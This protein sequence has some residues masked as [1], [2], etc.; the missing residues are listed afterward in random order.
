M[1]KRARGTHIPGAPLAGLLSARAP[2]LS[3]LLNQSAEGARPRTRLPR[4]L[5]SRPCEAHFDGSVRGS[6]AANRRRRFYFPPPLRSPTRPTSFPTHVVS[7]SCSGQ[8]GALVPCAAAFSIFRGVEVASSPRASG[9]K[10]LTAPRFLRSC[11]KPRTVLGA[12]SA[13][14]SLPVGRFPW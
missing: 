14:P 13:P 12:Q 8:S 10:R 1:L 9:S 2:G 5:C 4:S 7:A 11:Q 3:R 6:L